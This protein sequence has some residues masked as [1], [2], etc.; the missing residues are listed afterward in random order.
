MFFVNTYEIS[1]VQWALQNSRYRGVCTRPF[2]T[3][4]AFVVNRLKRYRS[5]AES[6]ITPPGQ[7]FAVHS[8]KM[9]YLGTCREP[10]S[11]G[12]L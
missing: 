5:F 6:S 7:T 10:L 3:G 9:P 1:A 4:L 12:L 2:Q 11:A 8:T